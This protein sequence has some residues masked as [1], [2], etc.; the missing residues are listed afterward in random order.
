MTNPW[1]NSRGVAG[2]T[3]I[4]ADSQDTTYRHK[5]YFSDKATHSFSSISSGLGTI[6]PL[7]MELAPFQ[8]QNNVPKVFFCSALPR[9]LWV[10]RLAGVLSPLAGEVLGPSPWGVPGSW[11]EFLWKSLSVTSAFTWSP[12]DQSIFQRD[13]WGKREIWSGRI[14]KTTSHNIHLFSHRALGCR[15]I[16]PS[17]LPRFQDSNSVVFPQSCSSSCLGRAIWPLHPHFGSIIRT[18]GS[19]PF[20]F[21]NSA[22][23]RWISFVHYC[24]ENLNINNCATVL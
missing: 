21:T 13:R 22:D 1:W 12:V 10:T 8:F 9:C 14:C 5:Q 16:F 3:N 20:I 19:K 17:F 7:S 4:L 2:K 15:D 6:I 18:A 24:F 11:M 23:L